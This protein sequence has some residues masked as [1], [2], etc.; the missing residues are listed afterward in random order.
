MWSCATDLRVKPSAETACKAYLQ[1]RWFAKRFA[2]G[3][4]AGVQSGKCW[5]GGGGGVGNCNFVMLLS[6]KNG[7]MLLGVDGGRLRPC[8][9]RSDTV[10]R[11]RGGC[12]NGQ[13]NR[14]MEEKSEA[15]APDC[16]DP[17]VE[18]ACNCRYV[19]SQLCCRTCK[20]RAPD[21]LK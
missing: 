10:R 11:P 20:T 9:K 4:G 1:V 7:R 13:V 5:G 8:R 12:F 2:S 14:C 16:A 15:R 17:F 3:G 21:L 6:S 18:T 19:R